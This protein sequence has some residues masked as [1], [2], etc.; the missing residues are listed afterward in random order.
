MPEKQPRASR[1]DNPR[2]PKDLRHSKCFAAADELAER[3]MRLVRGWPPLEKHSVGGQLARA[4]VSVPCNL[5][6]S[7]SRASAKERHRFV[8]IADGS[9]RE[10]GYLVGLAGRLGLL[11]P[12]EA[13]EL[14]D[15]HARATKLLA[16]QRA[17]ASARS[18]R[19][20]RAQRRARRSRRASP[21]DVTPAQ[22]A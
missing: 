2:V 16:G 14:T 15:L 13:A 8:E 21:P 4:A 1:A 9:L 3:C 12:P 6:E 17:R 10:A 5:A 18:L 19:Q 20:G 11:R 22:A 7:T